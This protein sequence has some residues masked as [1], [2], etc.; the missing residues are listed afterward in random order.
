M[1]QI[2]SYATPFCDAAVTKSIV[3]YKHHQRIAFIADVIQEYGIK[4]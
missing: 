3:K 4:D 1:T 2:F